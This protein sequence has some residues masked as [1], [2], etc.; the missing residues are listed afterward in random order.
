PL[1][2]TLDFLRR[3]IRTAYRATRLRTSRSNAYLAENLS[4]MKTVQLFNREARN[5][6]GFDDINLDLLEAHYEQVRWFSLFFPA[7]NIIGAL[8]TGLILYYAGTQLLGESVAN[9]VTIGVL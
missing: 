7:V 4:G 8:S 5:Q 9:T 1:F 6:R 3:K 2:L